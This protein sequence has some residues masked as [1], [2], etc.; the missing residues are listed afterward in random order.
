[1]ITKLTSDQES[2]IA[3]YR[4][5]Y[6]GYATSTVTDE[7]KATKAAL[8]LAEIGGVKGEVVFVDT[9]DGGEKLYGEHYSSIR[10]SL[11]ASHWDSLTLSSSLSDSLRDSISDSISDSLRYSLSSSRLERA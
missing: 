5:R 2:K 4:D 3:E 6:F 11:S 9:P 8:R 1:M 7:A 10:Y